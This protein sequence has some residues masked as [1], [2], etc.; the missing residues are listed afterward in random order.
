M[1]VA[2]RLET[3]SRSLPSDDAQSER[4]VRIFDEHYRAVTAY[5]LRR[6]TPAEAEDAVSE[7]F[8]VAWRRLEEVPEDAK[9]WLLG[10]ARRVLANQ[11]RAAGR[12]RALLE[13]AAGQPANGQEQPRRPDVLHA[14]AALSDADREVLLLVA[15]DGLSVREAALALRCTR[16]A[17]K[18]RLHRARRRFRAALHPERG[19]A[20]EP[21]TPRRLEECHEKG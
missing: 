2:Q 18:V 9:P 16:A 21:T 4:F 8:L 5:A 12:R 20:D 11:H 10:V 17:A 7:T 6:T 3:L 14:L 19:A 15:W 1:S 13:R